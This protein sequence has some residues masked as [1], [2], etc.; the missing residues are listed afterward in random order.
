[1]GEGAQATSTFQLCNPHKPHIWG[2]ESKS[3]IHI[4]NICKGLVITYGD[5]GGG[6]GGCHS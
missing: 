6:G 3:I 2:G 1:M 4:E 5:G